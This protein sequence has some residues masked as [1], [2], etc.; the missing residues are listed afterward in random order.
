[1]I[2]NINHGRYDL[3]KTDGQNSVN[4]SKG[5]WNNGS[6]TFSPS[7]GTGSSAGVKMGNI[8]G[9]WGKTADGEVATAYYYTIY[10][11]QSNTNGV[12]TGY[13]ST[14]SMPSLTDSGLEVKSGDATNYRG[15]VK[16][17]DATY[18]TGYST[19]PY[20]N[21]KSAGWTA[22]YDTVKTT[23]TN[24]L[25]PTSTP[26][27]LDDHIET[28]QVN[29]TINGVANSR[30]YYVTSSRNYAYIKYGSNDSNGKIVAQVQHNQYDSGA[31][32]G[33]YWDDSEN[34]VTSTKESR[35]VICKKND[36]T[37]A[38]SKTIYLKQGGWSNANQV[39]YVRK[40][41]AST[42]SVMMRTTVSRGT[43][44]TLHRGTY[45]SSKQEYTWTINL[46]KQVTG[47]T[48]TKLYVYATTSG[49]YYEGGT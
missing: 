45:N 4:V 22:A 27:T 37:T 24:R 18:Y 9:H 14:H 38:A 5:S 34:A 47:G 13:S 44:L 7:V 33:I 36:G 23:S 35:N 42:G 43:K 32:S 26:S 48:N 20:T 31:A 28:K 6:I 8:K 46:A 2:A 17:G 30:N 10:D 1:L 15:W 11:Y 25:F 39:V 29:S 40:D 16:L 49:S 3:G 19:T 12:T 21:G 41:N